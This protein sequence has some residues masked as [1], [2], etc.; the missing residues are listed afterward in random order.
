[1]RRKGK[2][3][4]LCDTGY[5]LSTAGSSVDNLWMTATLLNAIF[6]YHSKFAIPVTYKHKFI[7]KA[8]SPFR[9]VQFTTAYRLPANMD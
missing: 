1:M 2:N 3:V 5:L 9:T 6:P 7:D 8:H 4:L